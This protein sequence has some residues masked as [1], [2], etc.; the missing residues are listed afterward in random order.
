MGSELDPTVPSAPRGTRAC[1]HWAPRRLPG[2]RDTHGCPPGA[3]N[4]AARATLSPGL[5]LSCHRHPAN[6]NTSLE[7]PPP[8]SHLRT[9]LPCSGAKAGF[10]SPVGEPRARRRYVP[11]PGRCG[12]RRAGGDGCANRSGF[13]QELLPRMWTCSHLAT[14]Q[15]PC[16]PWHGLGH[17]RAGRAGDGGDEGQ[18]PCASPSSPPQPQQSQLRAEQRL[19]L[20]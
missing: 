10:P 6:S 9:R 11:A 8:R 12:D 18:S 15:H 4:L 14:L 5:A 17:G 7:H 20:V 2:W 1:P 13:L 16:Q 3:H 19:E